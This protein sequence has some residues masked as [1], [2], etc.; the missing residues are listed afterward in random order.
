MNPD[1]SPPWPDSGFPA[2]PY[3]GSRPDV[4]F[5][6]EDALTNPITPDPSAPSG[7]RVDRRCLDDWLAGRGAVPLAQRVPVLGYGSNANPEKISWM[8]EHRGLTGPVVALQVRTEGLAA[9]WSAGRRVVDDQRPATLAAVPGVAEE[10]V[11]WLTAPEQFAALDAVEGR[12]ADPP[13]YRLARI[14]TGSVIVPETG[15][16]LDRLCAY[17]APERPTGVAR[18]DRRPLLVGG[19]PV[20]CTQLGQADAAALTG[21]PGADGLDTTT[22]TGPPEP[23]GWPSR[24]FVYGSLMPGQHAW[25]L[26]RGHADPLVLPRPA[27]LSVGGVADTGHGYPALSLDGTTGVPGYLVELADPVRSLPALDDH[28]GPEYRR[29]RVV[30]EDGAVCWVWLWTAS[31]DGHVPLPGGW[32]ARR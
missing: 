4:S 10:H 9:V 20:R 16:V 13:R 3:P 19:S 7:W 22:V 30:L 5:V 2:E 32:A 15:A 14:A 23:D 25:P 12:S 27:F 8:R 21:E 24:I 18:T 29:I 6:H 17:V 26:A 11:V 1:T 31:R 28:E